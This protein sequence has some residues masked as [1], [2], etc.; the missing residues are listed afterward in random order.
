MTRKALILLLAITTGV[1]VVA[2]FW[3]GDSGVVAALWL[4]AI[5]GMLLSL[6]LPFEGW[7]RVEAVRSIVR[8]G[9]KNAVI[10]KEPCSFG[11]YA[12]KRHVHFCE[13]KEH[14]PSERLVRAYGAMKLTEKLAKDIQ[15]EWETGMGIAIIFLVVWA[16][17]AFGNIDSQSPAVVVPAGFEWS[18]AVITLLVGFFKLAS[19][20]QCM[21][22]F[23]KQNR[24]I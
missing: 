21:H 10:L 19:S 7:M 20:A 3:F 1:V 13:M 2:L 4:C 9:S 22:W 17:M 12:T 8:D 16:T 6:K 11:D 15:D 5:Y 18:K 24:K 14:E 23:R